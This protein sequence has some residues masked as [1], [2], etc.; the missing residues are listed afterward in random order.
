MC[1]TCIEFT[2]IKLYIMYNAAQKSY[3]L[4]FLDIFV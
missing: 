3:D 4:K 1:R 2:S